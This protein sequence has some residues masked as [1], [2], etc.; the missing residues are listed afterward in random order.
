LDKIMASYEGKRILITGGAGFLATNLINLLK[1]VDC[2][3]VRLDQP[4]TLCLPVNG[5]AKIED[6]TGD[7][8][9]RATWDRV[10]ADIDLIFHFAA[11]TSAYV[12]NADP[13]SD[14]N[15]NVVP[16]MHLLE[17]CR[18]QRW[19]S[20]V[21]FSST[22]TVAGIPK[23]LPVDETHPDNPM[24]VYDL[25]KLMAEQYLKWYISQGIVQGAILRLA[26][27]YG[28][29]PKGSRS[30]RGI[31]NQMIRQALTGKA[32]TVYKPADRLRDY[33]YVEDVACAFLKAV[34]NIE[35]I[36]GQHFIIGSG[37][38][39]NLEQVMNLV[40]DRVALKTGQRVAVNY[41]Q[42]PSPQLPIEA[43]NFVADS[44]RFSQATGWHAQYLLAEG[45][46]RTVEVFL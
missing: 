17:T 5:I 26:N 9:E 3:I 7:V 12:A 37:Q 45:I 11:Q 41:I 16:M 22:V 14:L 42:P 31:L 28:P 6:V 39:H 27:V 36:N 20:T 24:T 15:S 21:L 40:A 25:H 2:H 8:R 10:L 30:D 23:K 35:A 44:R 18:Q 46:D 43:R 32:V 38:A 1:N 34:R 19:R 29:G 33:V 13:L 4:G